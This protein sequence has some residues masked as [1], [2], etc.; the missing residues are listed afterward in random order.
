MYY[1]YFPDSFIALREEIQHHPDLL[2]ILTVQKEQDF[3]VHL[4]EIAAYCSVVLDGLYTHE[5]QIKL[6]DI[7]VNK[8]KAKRVI[9]VKPFS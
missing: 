4:A 8:L 6:C 5:D 9:I 7:L 1:E 2:T 3:H